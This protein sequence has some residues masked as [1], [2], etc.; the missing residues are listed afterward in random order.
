MFTLLDTSKDGLL[1]IDEIKKGLDT[2]LGQL[3][4]DG[5][6]YKE[7]VLAMDRDGDGVIDY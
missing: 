1:S 2:V 7:L 4:G 3:K 5:K 6:N